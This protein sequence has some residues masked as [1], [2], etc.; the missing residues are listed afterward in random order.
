MVRHRPN[1]KGWESIGWVN[2]KARTGEGR[3]CTLL[4]AFAEQSDALLARQ[5]RGG[6]GAF[7]QTASVR[8]GG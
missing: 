3:V 4:V 5:K 8:G 6:S 2:A 1:E 7:R